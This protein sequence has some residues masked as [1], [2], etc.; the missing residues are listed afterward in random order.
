MR[1]K[2][3]ITA[4]S[5]CEDTPDN[6]IASI[7]KAVQ[8]GADCVEIDLRPDADGRLW[9]SHD[10]QETTDTLVSLESAF[11]R[12]HTSGIAVNCDLKDRE[13]LLPA[14]DLAAHYGIGPEQLIFSG[15]VDPGLL[16]QY[17]EIARRSRIFLNSEVLVRTLFPD[18]QADRVLQADLLLANASL[19]AGFL[20]ELGAVAMNLPYPYMTPAFYAAFRALH[21]EL[22]LWTLNE[23]DVLRRHLQL[24][25]L[26]ITTRKPSLALALR[27]VPGPEED[28]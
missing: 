12:I 25:L 7:E 28:P 2:I 4:H 9:L 26:N 21:V 8:L 5:G 22:S 27:D 11:E 15:S 24:E 17:P 14:L 1:P 18:A 10:M 6:S 19:A 3:M 16:R 20:H 23:E 13:A